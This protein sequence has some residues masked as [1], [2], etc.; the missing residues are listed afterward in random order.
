M[1]K[2]SKNQTF[3]HA[4]AITLLL[5]LLMYAAWRFT[6]INEKYLFVSYL[7]FLTAIITV[8]SSIFIIVT[9]WN[10]TTL[11]LGSFS[12]SKKIDVLIPTYKEPISIIEKT[13]KAASKLDY[14]C[15]VMVLDDAGREDVKN[16][17]KE[18]GLKYLCRGHNVHAKAGNLNF[19]LRHCKSEYVAVFDADHIP[20]KQAITLLMQYFTSSDIAFVQSPQDH[21]NTDALQFLN[22]KPGT[23]IW[24]DQSVFY[25]LN[26]PAA[27][28]FHIA[29]C[30]GTG[31]IYRRKAIN[32][33]GGIPCETLTEDTHTSLKLHMNN[34]KSVY[35]PKP[36]AYGVSPSDNSEYFKTRHRWAQGNFQMIQKEKIFTTKK[37]SLL[38]KIFYLNF[39]IQSI[40][41]FQLLILI[42]LPIF[43]LFFGW[44][45][46]IVTPLNIFLLLGCPFIFHFLLKEI[47]NGYTQF[48][49]NEILS[50]MRFPTHIKAVFGLFKINIPWHSSNKNIKGKIDWN[51]L[52]PQIF[53]LFFCA[54][55]ILYGFIKLYPD[56]KAGPIICS[57]QAYFMSSDN[58]AFMF[59]DFLNTP[60]DDGYSLELLIMC[61]FWS[62]FSI[63]RISYYLRLLVKKVKNSSENFRFKIHFP[64]YCSDFIT[65]SE[66]LTNRISEDAIAIST[67]KNGMKNLSIGKTYFLKILLPK[68]D[69]DIKTRYA[70]IIGSEYIFNIVDKDTI[71]NLVDALY[72]VAWHRYLYFDE[73]PFSTLSLFL[74]RLF[75]RQYKNS[76]KVETVIFK[77]T[78]NQDSEYLG[79]V[80]KYGE[81]L[82]IFSF[83]SLVCGSLITVKYPENGKIEKYKVNSKNQIDEILHL[84]KNLDGTECYYYQ[85][86][87][88]TS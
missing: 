69:S 85:L 82:Y 25:D 60:L 34:W 65:S 39:L 11:P 42:F 7:F 26:L 3:R 49:N 14:P 19:G 86:S 55:S 27:N 62:F 72:S 41:E 58:Q 77:K 23:K 66:V 18:L 33:I 30:V 67:M 38:G 22:T 5:I 9:T 76:R 84:T 53:I 73:T 88:V 13:L 15:C 29:S 35:I 46:F 81:C 12:Y 87:R 68:G 10:N 75:H 70:G 50:I 24:H 45:S 61:G 54:V 17:T 71:S 79:F 21:F 56:F 83:S 37:L 52:V 51:L 20:Q 2:F 40:N 57:L 63:F 36:I 80:E 6:I 16:L 4:C 44:Q 43:S 28:A 74:K 59:N 32:D 78:S 1:E 8:I 48:W 64:V 31:V 47:T